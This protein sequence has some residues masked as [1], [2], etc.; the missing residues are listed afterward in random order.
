MIDEAFAGFES[1]KRAALDLAKK[2]NSIDDAARHNTAIIE[3]QEKIS[4]AQESQLALMV[5]INIFE[6]GI[7]NFESDLNHRLVVVKAS[8]SRGGEWSTPD[9]YD[10][11]NRAGKVLGRIMRHPQAPDIHP[12]LWTIT[13]GEILWDTRS[14]GDGFQ[15]AV[16]REY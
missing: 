4:A 3:I 16:G 2:I 10:V 15:D 9:D 12:W 7:T 14:G 13:A 1:L 11:C 6:K 8:E 5:Q